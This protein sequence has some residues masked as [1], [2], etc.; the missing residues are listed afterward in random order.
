MLTF[1]Q[2]LKGLIQ[3][4]YKLAFHC[5]R[6]LYLTPNP[7][8]PTCPLSSDGEEYLLEL[9]ERGVVRIPDRFKQLANYV[10]DH[11]VS[12]VEQFGENGSEKSIAFVHR[13]ERRPDRNRAYEAQLSFKDPRMAEM[14]FD[15]DLCGI[16]CNYY[17]RQPYFRYQPQLINTH[18]RDTDKPCLQGKF[19]KDGGYRMLAYTL[20][21]NDIT[22][23]DTHMEYAIGSHRD[24]TN[25][26]DVRSRNSYS[27][28]EVAQRYEIYPLVGERGTLFI[29]ENGNG[30]HR[31]R[32][33]VDRP[34]VMINVAVVT[35][36]ESYKGDCRHFDSIEDW[37][38]LR[39][40]PKYIRRMMEKV[41][42][43]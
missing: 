2:S 31:A 1:K 30:F 15:P 7:F 22:L 4:P 38:A 10:V 5:R 40:Y 11:Y 35:S 33:V 20:L 21:L 24:R 8:Q 36:T 26:D 19:H 6:A 32:Y 34:R 13:V 39:Q 37:P 27:D 18:L 43:R 29:F 16:F 23:G 3:T 41:A 14:Y 42:A 12:S 28:E 9:K 25:F 17:R